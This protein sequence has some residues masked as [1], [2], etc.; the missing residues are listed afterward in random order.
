MAHQ[1]ES[2]FGRLKELQNNP[3]VLLSIEFNS[4]I[5]TPEI[6]PFEGLVGSFDDGFEADLA[7]LIY[8]QFDTPLTEPDDQFYQALVRR[9]RL[10]SRK[11]QIPADSNPALLFIAH[12]QNT[13]LNYKGIDVLTLVLHPSLRGFGLGK[14]FTDNFENLAWEMGYSFTFGDNSETRYLDGFLR[15]G[16]IPTSRLQPETCRSLGI[17]AADNKTIRFNPHSR[18]EESLLRAG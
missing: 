3:K 8:G 6:T 12:E 14:A 16:S 17:P 18:L 2:H 11:S 4:H 15:N 10:I 7:I 1:K 5:K 13:Q 9:H